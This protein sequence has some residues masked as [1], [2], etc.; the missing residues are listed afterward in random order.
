[1]VS[2]R[3]GKQEI[4]IPSGKEREISQVLGHFSTT[5][6]KTFHPN[7]ANNQDVY[8]DGKLLGN[9][10]GNIIEELKKEISYAL[11]FG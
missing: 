2:I 11:V 1:M 7:S 9:L 8:L 5:S 3:I 6:G 4:E 10:A